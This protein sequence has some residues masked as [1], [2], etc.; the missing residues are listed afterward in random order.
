[1]EFNVANVVLEIKDSIVAALKDLGRPELYAESDENMLQELVTILEPIQLA[2]EMLSKRDATLMTSE[3][4]ILFLLNRLADYSTTIK[5]E[6]FIALKR[7]FAERRKKGL[8]SLLVKLH[9]VPKTTNHIE[10]FSYTT[11]TTTI[12]L[13]RSLLM[14][15]N[16]EPERID[17]MLSGSIKEPT[18]STSLSDI[19]EQT[20]RTVT[21]PNKLTMITTLC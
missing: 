7:R 13:A 1:M 5:E 17:S 10:V 19:L 8:I 14:R 2:V 15:L 21:Q 4:V 9:N 3:G 6:M 20:I 12:N 11:K 16:S 18:T